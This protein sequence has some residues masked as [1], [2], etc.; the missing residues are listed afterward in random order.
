MTDPSA[1]HD[2]K[3]VGL[4]VYDLPKPETSM[5]D[6][7]ARTRRGR[8]S[9]ILLVLV[10]AAPVL[11]SYFTYYV[12][13]PAGRMHHGELIE[14]QRALP[15]W[16]GTDL[17]GQAL[18]LDQLKG[19]W[20][21]VAVGS[22]ACAEKCERVLFVQ[23][24]LQK[25]LNKDSDRLERVWLLTDPTPPAPA[26]LQSIEGATVLKVPAD[27]LAQWLAPA[28]GQALEE[29]LY[30]VDPMGHWM[31]RFPYPQDAKLVAGMKRDLE[32]LMRASSSWDKP[33][34]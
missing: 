31:M 26:L 15:A 33:G 7:A 23:R 9:L 18:A 13:R 11:L 8:W 19:Q 27:S 34:R 30:L 10:C 21:L 29:H 24:Q 1:S 6:G 32:R 14:P 4:T 12:I 28:S 20:L 2:L 3:P 16:P 17:Q 25:M 22:G 5:P